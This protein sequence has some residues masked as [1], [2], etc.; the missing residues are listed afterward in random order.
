[1]MKSN[2]VTP[3]QAS[4]SLTGRLATGKATVTVTATVQINTWFIV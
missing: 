3:K 2:T 4:V 1:M